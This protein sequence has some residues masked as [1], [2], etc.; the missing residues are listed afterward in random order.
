VR[1]VLCTVICAHCTALCTVSCAQ[2]TV[3]CTELPQDT[4]SWVLSAPACLPTLTPPFLFAGCSP[5]SSGHIAVLLYFHIAI[6]T[7]FHIAILPYCHMAILPYRD[8]AILYHHQCFPLQT[9]EESPRTRDPEAGLIAGVPLSSYVLRRS[10]S[11]HCLFP[12]KAGFHGYIYPIPCRPKVGPI[13]GFVTNM[14]L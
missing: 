11:L 6:L 8:I 13:Q 4:I 12:Y 3:Q 2:C 9:E 7:H 14:T 1:T 5:T 10:V